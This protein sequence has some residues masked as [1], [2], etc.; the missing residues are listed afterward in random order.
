MTY[1]FLAPA[2]LNLFLY[3]NS[4]RTDGY[5]NLQ[6]VFDFINL[7]D[8][9]CFSVNSI[10]KISCISN[11]KT[12]N[13]EDNLVTRAAKLLRKYVKKPQLGVQ[14]DLTKNIPIGAGLGGG[15]SD[16]ATTLLALNKL[17]KLSLSKEI[18]MSI[19]L[20]L[21]ADVPI[22]IY[23][24]PAWAEGIGEKLTPFKIPKRYY[25]LIY[26]NVHVATAKIFSDINL[27]RNSPIIQKNTLENIDLFNDCKK[28]VCK[29]Y[30]E[31][32]QALLWLNN[33]TTAYLTGTGSAIFGVF[34]KLADAEY[35]LK[36][37]PK[38]YLAWVVSNEI[39]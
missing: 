30:L 28:I 34:N 13:I 9:L 18:L 21:G 22:F 33:Y 3:I 12:I 20:K 2:K 11:N 5:H 6:T 37:V 10:G 26:P 17:W 1:N 31:I 38:N 32:N 15:S 24:K 35:I 25:L 14:I 4:Q 29:H 19:G 36:K 27:T 8:N 16:A 23:G 39:T 7:Y